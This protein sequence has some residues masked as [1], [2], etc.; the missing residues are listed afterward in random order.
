MK[1]FTNGDLTDNRDITVTIDDNYISFYHDYNFD[2]DDYFYWM[3]IDDWFDKKEHI[4]EKK[5]FK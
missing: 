5:W 3:L 2:E 1:T 4:K